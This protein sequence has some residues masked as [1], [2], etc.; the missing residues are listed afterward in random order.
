MPQTSTTIPNKISGAQLFA[1]EFNEL[2]SAVNSNAQDFTD[3]VSSIASTEASSE[4]SLTVIEN[5]SISIRSYSGELPETADDGTVAFF[6]DNACM[7]YFKNDAWHKISSGDL[8]VIGNFVFTID[9]GNSTTFKLPLATNQSHQFEINWGDGTI[10]NITSS[11]P[12]THDYG[13][14]NTLAEISINGNLL[15]LKFQLY[16][17]DSLKLT[18]IKECTGLKFVDSAASAFWKAKNLI[19]I[20]NTTSFETKDVTNFSSFYRDCIKLTQVPWMD[21]SAGTNFKL[22]FRTCSQITEMP[23]FDFG[24][25][26]GAGFEEVFFL[27]SG[28]V[29]LSNITVDTSLSTSIKQLFYG[30][31]KLQQTFPLN[32]S[33]VTNMYGTFRNTQSLTSLPTI[34]TDNVEIFSYTFRDMKALVEMPQINTSSGKSFLEAWYQCEVLTT[35][36]ELDFSSATT[37]WDAWFGCALTP[38]SIENI[39][40]SLYNSGKTGLSTS[41]SGGSNAAQST[42]T[43]DAQDYFAVLTGPS[44]STFLPPGATE[45]VAGRGWSISFNS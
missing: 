39:L 2:N 23:D 9:T 16:E 22:M 30:C 15:G 41:L 11:A 12:I 42:W 34:A 8:F 3:R 19:T 27:C 32:T 14:T 24:T 4:S 13:S 44:T 40:K 28:L 6:T 7:V 1:T 38:Q 21:L 20:D 29:D 5:S 37:F 18:E 43:Q 31:T 17:S 36:P 26:T 35:F 25:P 10:E 33:A 45:E